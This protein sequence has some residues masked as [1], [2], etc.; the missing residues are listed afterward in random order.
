MGGGGLDESAATIFQP[1]PIPSANA[2]GV[3]KRT[4][5]AK[6]VGQA[7]ES[8]QGFQGDAAG[9]HERNVRQGAFDRPEIGRSE[10]ICGKDR[11]LRWGG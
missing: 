7:F 4:A 8:G 11:G 2:G 9:G 5:H 10:L 6:G 3:E 1:G